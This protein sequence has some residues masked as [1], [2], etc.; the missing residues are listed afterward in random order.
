MKTN[1]GRRGEHRSTPPSNRKKLRVA[2]LGVG[3]CAS[4]LVQG[5]Q[6]YRNAPED[7]FVPALMHVNLGG[8]HVGDIE[9][10]AAFD[11]DANKVGKDLSEAIFTEP[12]NTYKFSDVPPLR[13]PVHRG[14]THD[15]LGKYLTKVIRKAPGS[16][17]ALCQA[18]ARG[19]IK[20]HHRPRRDPPLGRITGRSPRCRENHAQQSTVVKPDR[21]D[22]WRS[23]ELDDCECCLSAH[24]RGTWSRWRRRTG[25]CLLG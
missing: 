13:V 20:K 22:D 19:Q 12:N 3:N 9:F 6:F 21:F 16:T 2:I 17:D 23:D 10:S 18:M 7:Q 8:Y 14:M 1:N 15:S 5:V 24:S 4:S 11:I 25:A